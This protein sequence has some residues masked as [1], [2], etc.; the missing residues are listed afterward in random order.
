MSIALPSLSLKSL[1]DVCSEE[2][3]L[4]L[5]DSTNRLV[6]FSD[7]RLEVLPMPTEIHQAIAGFLY[8]ALLAFVTEHDLG[9]VPFPPLRIRV[10]AGK[11]RQ[12]DVL[13]LAKQNLHKRHNCV[14]DGAD[15]VMEVV[16]DDPKDRVRDYEEK[17]VEYARGGIAEY[18]IV[19]PQTQT[20]IVYRLEE[21]Q[22]VVHGEYRTGDAATS[23]LLYGFGIDVAALFAAAADVPN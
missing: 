2:N 13:F 6:E 15:L 17:R 18:W 14:W 1:Q 3:Y 4:S 19:D 21:G 16:S 8:H 9:K 10:V 7:G 12:P 5:S 20:V 11:I 22:Y 23:A